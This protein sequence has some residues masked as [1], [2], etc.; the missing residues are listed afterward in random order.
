MS[1]RLRVTLAGGH[2]E[3][4]DLTSTTAHDLEAL[5]AAG[6][7]GKEWLATEHDK[8]VIRV[9]A[10]VAMKVEGKANHTASPALR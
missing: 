5:I 1:E 2:K 10:I 9:A 8:G 3:H 4:L 6:K 7:V